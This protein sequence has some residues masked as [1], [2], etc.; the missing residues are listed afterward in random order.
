MI[1]RKTT[2]IYHLKYNDVR[3][4]YGEIVKESV[5]PK[6]R[7]E[8]IDEFWNLDTIQKVPDPNFFV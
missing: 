2:N 8:K 3:I 7:E 5:I 6:N 4:K 1:K